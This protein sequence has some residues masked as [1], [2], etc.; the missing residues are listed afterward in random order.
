MITLTLINLLHIWLDNLSPA[1]YAPTTVARYSSVIR[2]FLHWYDQQERR[3]A[4]LADLTPITLVNY[5]STLQQTQ[6][7]ATTNVHIAA[8]RAW[9][10]WLTQRGY[11]V[12][13]PTSY[14]KSIS[15]VDRDAPEP[16]FNQAVN[17][18]LRSA[19]RTRYGKRDYAICQMLLQ[20]GMRLGECQALT[21]QDITFQERKA[22][23]L[24]RSGKGDK[25]RTIPLNGSVR[26]ALVGYIA[27]I[28]GCDTKA[29]AVAAA[30]PV[31]YNSPL[32]QSQKGNQLS[33]TAIWRMFKQL[34]AD[35]AS[36]GLVPADTTTHH[37]RHTFAHH[38]LAKNPGD[39]VG[40]ARL[41]G[42]TNLNTTKIY[43]QPTFEELTTRVDQIPLNAYA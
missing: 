17:A 3:P 11:L 29:K 40:L 6:S 23:V 10:L 8:L 37:L 39:L 5:R 18:L 25:A 31:N 30:W 20:T 28:L 2:R 7:T 34:V 35:C 12:E 38:Y 21:W 14:L 16:L 41:L 22:F 27:P 33:T 32:W 36:R 13:N 15:R 9:C 42:H 24:I 43:T 26:S 19:H 1:D 4:Q